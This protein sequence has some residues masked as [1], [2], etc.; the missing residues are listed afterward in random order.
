MI[1]EI[2][3]GSV[4]HMHQNRADITIIY[5]TFQSI[6]RS[7]LDFR[8]SDNLSGTSRCLLINACYM[9]PEVYFLTSTI[10][11]YWVDDLQATLREFRFRTPKRWCAC[12]Y[13]QGLVV[14]THLLLNWYAFLLRR[15]LL[16]WSFGYAVNVFTILQRKISTPNCYT[17]AF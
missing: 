12:K 15:E 11:D 10:W 1:W 16:T 13:S 7:N 8:G 4:W 2:I 14:E 3:L 9:R 17:K 5:A 6:N